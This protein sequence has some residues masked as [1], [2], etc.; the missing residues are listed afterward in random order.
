MTGTVAT[1]RML[2]RGDLEPLGL[3]PRSSNYT[4]LAKVHDGD[5]ETLAVYKPIAG[6]TPLFD[7]PEGTLAAREVAAYVLAD[8][9][10]WPRVPP[11]VLRDGPHGPGAVQLFVPFDPNEHYFTMQETRADAFRRIALFDVVANNAD[12][13]AG[14]CLLAEDGELFVVDHGVCFHV[15]PKLRTVIWDF[16]G[17]PIPPELAADLGALEPRLREGD[18]RD[19][20]LGL[21]SDV[22]VGAAHGRLAGLLADGRFPEPGPGRP[23]PWPAV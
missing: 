20:L 7:F 5:R 10:G 1:L 18:L 22:E 9:L 15:E 3:L 11:T 17:E 12:R 6:E 23:Y 21:L 13:K 16:V 2:E 14:H 19:R 8:A 4:F